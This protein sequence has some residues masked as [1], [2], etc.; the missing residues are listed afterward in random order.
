GSMVISTQ[1]DAFVS[2]PAPFSGGTTVSG[3]VGTASI[4]EASTRSVV[5]PPNTDVN[6]LA[7]A[8]NELGLTARDV[9][10]IFQAIDRAGAL[11]GELVIL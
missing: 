9:I 10:A 4:D 6:Q 5:L 7:A 2:Q 11:Q 3:R 8:L 1:E